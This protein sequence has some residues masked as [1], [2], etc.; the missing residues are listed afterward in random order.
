VKK[1]FLSASGSPCDWPHT[2]KGKSIRVKSN[3][4]GRLLLGTAFGRNQ[5]L[6]RLYTQRLVLTQ[7]SRPDRR[8]YLITNFTKKRPIPV[9]LHLHGLELVCG[10]SVVGFS[11]PS[12]ILGVE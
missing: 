11:R 5:P 2:A 3:E 12:N 10:E 9:P 6:T 7:S 1:S 4:V 8:L